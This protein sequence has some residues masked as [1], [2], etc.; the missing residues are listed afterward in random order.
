[1]K[2]TIDVPRSALRALHS[3]L[4]DALIPM[5]PPVRD[6]LIGRMGGLDHD[7]FAAAV[8]TRRLLVSA[9]IVDAE[10]YIG[11]AVPTQGRTDWSLF[12]IPGAEGGVDAAWLMT[13]GTLGLDDDL[14]SVLGGA[15]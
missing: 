14:A 3:G 9:R 1:M 6:A 4:V 11:I 13:A 10:A 5:P 2:A 15:A 8:F 12:E 7:H